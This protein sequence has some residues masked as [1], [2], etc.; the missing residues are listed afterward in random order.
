MK[1]LYIGR[2]QPF[3]NGHLSVL[4][5]LS[6]EY[7]EIIIG[8][9]SSQDHDSSENPFSEAERTQ[10]IHRS[11][12]AEGIHN[13]RVVSIPDIH[14]P[15]QWVSHVRAIIPVFDVVITNNPFTRSLFIE[16][17]YDVDGTPYFK[18]Q[19]FSGKEIR[20]RM[21]HDEPWED[22]VPVAV[23]RFIKDI[24]GVQRVKKIVRSTIKK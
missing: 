9:G 10:M 19:L 15:P 21:L 4:R 7:S 14:D 17:G 13:Y 3:H 11:L 23:C 24:D 20:R 12:D 2:F 18:R 8:L 16:K 1:A 5:L 22:L 6:T